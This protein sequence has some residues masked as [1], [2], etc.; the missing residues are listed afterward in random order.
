MSKHW[1]DRYV[2]KSSRKVSHS[3]F[4]SDEFDFEADDFKSVL[5]ESQIDTLKKYRLSSGRKAIANF[6][7]IATGKE[8]PVKFSL[9]SQSYTDGKSVVISGDIDDESKFDVGVGL[10]LHEGSHIL[11]SD[12]KLLA[13]LAN[14]LH[15]PISVVTKA[16]AKGVEDYRSVIKNILNV[17]EDRRIDNYIYQNAPG[18]REYY[19]KLYEQ[20]FGD[21]VIGEALK[22]DQWVSETVDSYMNR[23]INIMNPASDLTTLRGFRK[24]W[25]LLDLHNI[26]RLKSTSEAL[27][28]S[29][30]IFDVILDSIDNAGPFK[31]NDP[32][33]QQGESGDG[34]GESGE[35]QSNGESGDDDS[36]DTEG[37][38]DADGDGGDEESNGG[39]GVS[40]N[41]AGKDG[42]EKQSNTPGKESLTDNKKRKL[43]QTINKQRD[44]LNGNVKKK[45]ISQAMQKQ[46]EAVESSGAEL[47]HVADGMIDKRGS[48]TK[49]C[50]VVVLKQLTKK[51]LDNR[52]VQLYRTDSKGNARLAISSTAV[53]TAERMGTILGKKLQVRNEART[54]VFNR[55]RNGSI[56]KRLIHSL[57]FDAESVFTQI[58]VDKFK[59]ANI[60]LSIDASSSMCGTKWEKTM[61]NAIALAKAVSMIQNLSMQISFRYTN[62]SLPVVLIAWDS[63]KESYQKVKSVFP[64]LDASG[65]TPEGL[66]FEA[67]Q[68]LLTPSSN[69]MDSYF[70]NI[71]DGEPCYSGKGFEYSGFTAFEHT[72][73]QVDK[74]RK[75][76]IVVLSYFVSDRRNGKDTYSGECFQKMYGKDARY[77]DINSVNEV[78]NTMNRMFLAK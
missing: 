35:G 53:A 77:I 71:S 57:G 6:V 62:E 52:D 70:V 40:S 28:L 18:Y 25:G 75:D 23:L 41:G 78:S 61:I 26:G 20:Y 12:F 65:T 50:D 67:I 42:K 34:E 56:D 51:M 31:K 2:G 11:L 69:D 74:I 58:H 73:K 9:G 68:K 59:K 14:G 55:Q 1:Y 32:Q 76:G 16:K 21:K 8:I 29:L 37:S 5:S 24:I 66:C 72:R 30:K 44:F 13:E 15:I 49:G 22:S 17:V 38:L 33:A 47:K 54:T 60:H 3:S 45:K 10:A 39:N 63:R 27:E 4:W 7:T 48:I 43:Q 64:Y 46:I 19:L 36:G